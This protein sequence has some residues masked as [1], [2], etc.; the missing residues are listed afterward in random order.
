MQYDTG[1]FCKCINCLTG[2][3]HLQHSTGSLTHAL[4]YTFNK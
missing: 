4:D 3:G 1:I 2:L